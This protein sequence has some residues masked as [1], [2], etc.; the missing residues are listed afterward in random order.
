MSRDARLCLRVGTRAALRL[1]DD[2][3]CVALALGALAAVVLYDLGRA[4]AACVVGDEGG[5]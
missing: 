4:G 2:G 5:D 3:L 1:L